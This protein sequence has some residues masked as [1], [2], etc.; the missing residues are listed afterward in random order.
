[1]RRMKVVLLV[2]VL[3]ACSTPPPKPDWPDRARFAFQCEDGRLWVATVPEGWEEGYMA[4]VGHCIG[5]LK[6]IGPR[7]RTTWIGK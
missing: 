3:S 1:M 7:Q 4:E 2:L 6:I 5:D